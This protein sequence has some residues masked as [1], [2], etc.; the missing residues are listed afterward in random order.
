MSIDNTFQQRLVVVTGAA[1]N[2]GRCLC[3]QLLNAGAFV[4]AIDLH[5]QALSDLR[6]SLPTQYQSAFAAAAVDIRNEQ[7]VQVAID[8]FRR[9]FSTTNGVFA[10]INNAAITHI[11]AHEAQ[12]TSGEVERRVMDVNFMGAVH[13]TY[14]VRD[15]IRRLG[16]VVVAISSVAGFAPLW[17]RTA[18]AASKYALHGYFDSLRAEWRNTNAHVLIACPAFVGVGDDLPPPAADSPSFQD[19][20]TSGAALRPDFVA[21]EILT[22]LRRRR[23]LALI[24]STSRVAYYMQRFLPRLYEWFMLRKIRES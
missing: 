7:A 14:A 9:V 2:L 15:D 6:E 22:A 4:G 10:L 17:G 3:R 23:R 8:E 11:A 21:Q 12:P 5:E 13:C 20:K 18:Y 16:G 24:G 1:G 19:K